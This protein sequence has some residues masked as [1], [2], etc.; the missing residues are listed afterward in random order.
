VNLNKSAIGY[1]KFGLK[2]SWK[3][4]SHFF[5]GPHVLGS[6]NGKTGMGMVL[7]GSPGRLSF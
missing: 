5:Q 7:T 1:E 6:Q 4:L 3:E 2:C